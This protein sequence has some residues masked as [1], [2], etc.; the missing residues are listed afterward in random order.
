MFSKL[1]EKYE[2]GNYTVFSLTDALNTPGIILQSAFKTL[3]PQIAKR[4]IEIPELADI[5]KLDTVVRK[6]NK[7]GISLS[8]KPNKKKKRAPKEA[9]KAVNRPY[10][11]R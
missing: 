5:T 6:L 1:L 8:Y 3:D 7:N 2:P 4:P 9:E 11:V 10:V